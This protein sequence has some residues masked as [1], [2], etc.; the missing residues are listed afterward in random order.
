[1]RWQPRPCG[2]LLEARSDVRT[3]CSNR[4][5]VAWHDRASAHMSQGTAA[6]TVSQQG[7]EV[8]VSFPLQAALPICAEAAGGCGYGDYPGVQDSGAESMPDDDA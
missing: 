6:A 4:L 1:M 2:G 7:F 3:Q 5:R 8:A